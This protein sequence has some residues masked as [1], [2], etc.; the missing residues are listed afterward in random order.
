LTHK[1]GF[2]KNTE[3]SVLWTSVCIATSATW[4]R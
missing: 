2:K 4:K 1:I 3:W